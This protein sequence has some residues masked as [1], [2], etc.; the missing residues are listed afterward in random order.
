M[1]F[2][3]IDVLSRNI[4]FYHFKMKEKQ[5]STDLRNNAKEESSQND[6]KPRIFLIKKIKANT[7]L[8]S[9]YLFPFQLLPKN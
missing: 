8:S 3:I 7:I 1:F 6:Y 2:S 9:P 5:F 4:Y